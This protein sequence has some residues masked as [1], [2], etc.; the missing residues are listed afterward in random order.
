MRRVGNLWPEIASFSALTRAAHRAALGKR[1]VLGVAL[2]LER[3]E[4]EALLLERE[5]HDGTWRPGRPHTFEVHDP[6]TRTITAAPFRDRVV[7][8]ALI[9]RL[10]PIFDRRMIRESFACRRGKGS[11][12]A[13][14]HARRMLRKYDW[15]LKL[16]IR[17]CFPSIRH[18]V[19]METLARVLK[20]RRVLALCRT[21][22]RGPG[23]EE[24][25][26]GI[27]IGNLT[28][29]WF[30]NLLLDRL[31]H[32]VKEVLQIPG[33]CRYLDDFV[34]FAGDRVTLRDA[35]GKI[36]EYLEETLH[37]TLKHRATLLAPAR[38]GLPFL[39]FQIQRGT[40]RVRPENLRRMRKRLRK[41][42]W[43]FE[44]GLIDE[45]DLAA[46]VG[47]MFAH[48]SHGSTLG[49]RRALVKGAPMI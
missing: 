2:F 26:V 38:V 39:G 49:L 24:N 12:A 37:L 22:L 42:R 25:A 1:H 31:D 13:L 32:H 29:Q 44:H 23:P 34:L 21:I 10:E 8:H 7:H 9:D 19:V 28:S 36:A 4:P 17:Q 30:A 18:E 11:H 48:L 27:P 14:R 15:F 16:D 47:S 43:Q 40:M 33:Y 20:D 41:R 5:L 6:K 3:L 46:S 45:D 35:H